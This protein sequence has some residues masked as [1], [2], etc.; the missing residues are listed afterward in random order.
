MV[1][2]NRMHTSNQHNIVQI[3]TTLII[4]EDG[5]ILRMQECE[6]HI[7]VVF[8]WVLFLYTLNQIDNRLLEVPL[9][10]LVLFIVITTYSTYQS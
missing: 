3:T 10:E 7:D 2:V 1:S 9:Q 6:I 5:L 4:E 8:C